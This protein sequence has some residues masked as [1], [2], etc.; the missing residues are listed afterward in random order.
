VGSSLI[1]EA[2]LAILMFSRLRLTR[3]VYFGKA[4]YS[5]TWT[6]EIQRDI[7]DSDG[8]VEAARMRQTRG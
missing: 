3:R 8:C 2:A 1:W 7:L 4:A 5:P 6:A